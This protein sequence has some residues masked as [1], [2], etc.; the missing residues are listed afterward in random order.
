MEPRGKRHSRTHSLEQVVKIPSSVAQVGKDFETAYVVDSVG[1][2]PTT[3]KSAMESSNAV[4]WKE[5][6]DS[7]ID[8]LCKNK[9]CQL[10]QLLKGL[11]TI[12]CRWVFQV[13]ENQD[14]EIKL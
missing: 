5:A 1:E 6:C 11:K 10:V 14:G 13:K 9:T 7:E 8:S 3:L 2:M 4:K 12:G